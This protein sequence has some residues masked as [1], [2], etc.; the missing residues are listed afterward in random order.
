MYGPYPSDCVRRGL[1]KPE[2][3]DVDSLSECSKCGCWHG[4]KDDCR[5]EDVAR[6]ADQRGPVGAH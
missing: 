5:F 3:G 4:E 1:T 2:P 6:L